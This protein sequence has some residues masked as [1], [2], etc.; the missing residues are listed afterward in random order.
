MKLTTL[1]TS[2][3]TTASSLASVGYTNRKMYACS[4]R[5]HTSLGSVSTQ[6]TV[7]KKHTYTHGQAHIS[8]DCTNWNLPW[9]P[10]N[11]S[12]RRTRPSCLPHDGCSGS[13]SCTGSSVAVPGHQRT[14]SG[15]RGSS[16][17]KHLAGKIHTATAPNDAKRNRQ[18]DWRRSGRRRPRTDD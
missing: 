9:R 14:F 8:S 7:Y 15:V 11:T 1:T 4:Y 6:Y 17:R 5:L 10:P 2:K 12:S 18:L 16:A 13:K 3:T